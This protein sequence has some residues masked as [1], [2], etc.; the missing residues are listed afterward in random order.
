MAAHR[1]VS[2]IYSF[3]GSAGRYAAVSA[4]GV[5]QLSSAE[6]RF[7]CFGSA[8]NRQRFLRRLQNFTREL[9]IAG[10]REDDVSPQLGGC[11][12]GSCS[13]DPSSPQQVDSAAVQIHIKSSLYGIE[14]ESWM[15]SKKRALFSSAAASNPLIMEAQYTTDL[16]VPLTAQMYMDTRIKPLIKYYKGRV[17]SISSIR[18]KLNVAIFLHLGAGSSLAMVGHTAWITVVAVSVICLVALSHWLVPPEFIEA[19]DN[20]LTALHGLDLRW[21][22]CAITDQRSEN[23]KNHLVNITE[24]VSLA[25]AAT[26]CKATLLPDQDD[27]LEAREVDEA[28]TLRRREK[29]HAWL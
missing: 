10:I 20:A 5:H 25:V 29:V 22:G 2:E 11:E 26:F 17:S 7:R 8:V 12:V 24:K 3:V 4:D 16:G 23:M 18:M 27:D 6:Q 19:V 15:S 13:S 28:V 14:P 1:I 9:A 21:H